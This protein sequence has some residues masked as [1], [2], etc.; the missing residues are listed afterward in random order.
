[1]L[2]GEDSRHVPLR[3]RGV[4]TQATGQ[5]PGKETRENIAIN[6]VCNPMGLKYHDLCRQ[7]LV[8]EYLR[9]M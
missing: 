6:D 8:L 5:T 3:R 9:I 2:R 1:M 4:N 7:V